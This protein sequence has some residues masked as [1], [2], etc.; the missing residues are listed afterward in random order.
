MSLEIENL[1]VTHKIGNDIFGDEAI[2]VC[3][4][5]KYKSLVTIYSFLS[6]IKKIK[7]LGIGEAQERIHKEIMNNLKINK[8]E[9]IELVKEDKLSDFETSI[10]FSVGEILN[11]IFER[12]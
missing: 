8:E 4:E 9:A 12:S 2:D 5:F 11:N 6:P 1:K 3:V 7:E 10:Y